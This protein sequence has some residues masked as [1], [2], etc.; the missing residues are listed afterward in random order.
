MK[1]LD[2]Y[3][4]LKESLKDLKGGENAIKKKI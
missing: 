3:L 1:N 2:L 4:K